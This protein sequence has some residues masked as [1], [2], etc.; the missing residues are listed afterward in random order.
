MY[1]VQTFT[2]GEYVSEVDSMT[3]A[4]LRQE[5]NILSFERK[6]LET[7]GCRNCISGDTS[8]IPSAYFCESTSEYRTFVHCENC[9]TVFEVEI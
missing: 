6:R 7:F 9:N 1:L 2:M 4:G 8:K 5:S 3:K